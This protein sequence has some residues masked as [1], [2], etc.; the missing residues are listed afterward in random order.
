MIAA[1][2]PAGGISWSDLKDLAV[3]QAPVGGAAAQDRDQ[4]G[5]P[6]VQLRQQ[7]V[8]E[9]V[10]VAVPLPPPVQRHQQQIRPGQ[11]RQGCGAPVQTQHRIAQRPVELSDLDLEAASGGY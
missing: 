2:P 6:A 3:V 4:G 8:A 7:H 1:V 10:V 5:L 9:Q 11:L